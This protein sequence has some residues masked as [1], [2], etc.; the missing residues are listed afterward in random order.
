[1]SGLINTVDHTLKNSIMNLVYFTLSGYIYYLSYLYQH[2][3]SWSNLYGVDQN[4]QQ[5]QQYRPNVTDKNEI[6]SLAELAANAYLVPDIR[7]TTKWRN[8]TDMYT[9]EYSYGWDVDGLRGHVFKKRIDP[10]VVISVKGTSLNSAKDKESANL[11]CS[12]NCCFSE[13]KNECDKNKLLESLPSMYLSLLIE[14]Y[15]DAQTRYPPETK[16]WFTGHSM[17]SLISALAAVKTCNYAVGFS[18]PGEQL[19]ANRIGLVHDCDDDGTPDD[20]NDHKRTI[21]HFGYYKDPIFVG[22]CGWLCS[23]AGYRMD[24]LCHHGNECTYLDTEKN[25]GKVD[26][27]EN[28][29]YGYENTDIDV[30][31]Y[32]KLGSGWIHTHTINFLIDKIIKPQKTV[33]MCVP[34]NNCTE[35]C[36]DKSANAL[37]EPYF[38]MQNINT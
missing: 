11:I 25:D 35:T 5:Q 20:G 29:V 31:T 6:L 27:E 17:G 36:K 8:S 33:P 14:A 32:G 19:F 26:G 34:V 4:Q 10:V 30:K 1:M 7:N 9:Y 38:K 21:F 3:F 12:C 13:C 28:I 16:F 23:V 37:K 2:I 15:T 24:S 18:S 22:N